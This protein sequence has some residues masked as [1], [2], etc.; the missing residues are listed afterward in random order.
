MNALASGPSPPREAEYKSD[1]V[2]TGSS[3]LNALPWLANCCKNI[4]QE[5]KKD[6]N[7]KRK[8]R[9]GTDAG[10]NIIPRVTQARLLE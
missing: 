9:K 2:R 10:L 5:G 8:S 6:G 7:R 3:A 1:A 4:K